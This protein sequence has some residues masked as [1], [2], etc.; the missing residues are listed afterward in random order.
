MKARRMRKPSATLPPAFSLLRSELGDFLYAPIDAE[1]GRPLTVL[2][3][4]TREGI[5]PWQEAA[6]LRQLPPETA[7]RNLA[8]IIAA[9]PERPQ[10]MDDALTVAGRLIAFLPPRPS[11]AARL[12][13]AT[14]GFR[15]RLS[16]PLG[17]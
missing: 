2:S 3:A 4:L 14:R 1:D 16:R 7:R 17:R 12:A 11:L 6:K 13:A 15:T 9:L 10:S 8:A 5:D